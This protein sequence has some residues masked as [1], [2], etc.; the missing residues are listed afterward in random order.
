[1]GDVLVDHGFGDFRRYTLLRYL[2]PES[3]GK[4]YVPESLESKL[5][6]Q[7]PTPAKS[8]V[9]IRQI[10]GLEAP[11]PVVK[12]KKT[13]DVRVETNGH[14]S[15]SVVP[16]KEKKKEAKTPAVIKPAAAAAPVKSNKFRPVMGRRVEPGKD[17]GSYSQEVGTPTDRDSGLQTE[18]GG[19]ALDLLDDNLSWAKQVTIQNLVIWEPAETPI[20]IAS[21]KKKGKKKRTR[22]SGLDFSTQKRKGKSSVNGSRATSPL[23][24][25]EPHE[26]K[27]SVDTIIAESNRWVVD[28]NAGETILHRASKMGYPDV[29]AYA[30]DMAGMGA[31]DK[32]YAG[33]TP[34][35]K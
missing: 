2:E 19:F 28:K 18:L 31:M 23:P 26:V 14:Q 10:F 29:V 7:S 30:L 12:Q 8:T 24:E 5:K 25:E 13:V 20:V 34:L 6:K 1:M 17:D 22:K 9:C 11:S 3:E 16:K 27:H 32:D 15:P 4:P 33:L 35:H 21:K